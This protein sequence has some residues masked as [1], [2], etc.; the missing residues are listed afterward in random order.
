MLELKVAFQCRNMQ[1]P[2]HRSQQHQANVEESI[3]TGKFDHATA[4]FHLLAQQVVRGRV[5]PSTSWIWRRLAGVW[6]L[7]WRSEGFQDFQ[8]F[9]GVAAAWLYTLWPC[10]HTKWLLMFASGASVPAAFACHSY[11]QARWCV[12]CFLRAKYGEWM[13]HSCLFSCTTL[14]SK[15]VD[16]KA[17]SLQISVEP[18][19]GTQSGLF[20]VPDRHHVTIGAQKGGKCP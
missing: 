13:Q 5:A 14:D 20:S 18:S 8:V 10:H 2:S 15:H 12:V 16:S 9:T 11:L 7:C 19:A 1:T 6:I 3:T 17:Q 4:T